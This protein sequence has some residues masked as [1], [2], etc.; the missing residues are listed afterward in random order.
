[1]LISKGLA[2]A[3]PFDF[4]ANNNPLYERTT[5]FWRDYVMKKCMLVV[6][7]GMVLALNVYG[8]VDKLVSNVDDCNCIEAS[9]TVVYME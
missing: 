8:I 3:F 1:M 5:I 2:S 4:R 6:F 9:T 7:V